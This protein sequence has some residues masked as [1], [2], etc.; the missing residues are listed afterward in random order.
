MPIMIET[1]KLMD[2]NELGN[3]YGLTGGNRGLPPIPKKDGYPK[4]ITDV[5]QAGGGA[6]M[7][8]SV[9]V[10]DAMR[11]LLDTE[12]ESV[13]AEG[14][15]LFSRELDV[16]DCGFI[17][18][19]FKNGAVASV[20]PSW[21]TRE[22][23][24]YHYDYYLNILQEN[25]VI[26]LDDRKQAVTVVRQNPVQDVALEAFGVNVDGLMLR[27]FVTSI[28]EG[29]H[30]DYCATGKDGLKALEIALAAYKSLKTG[31]PVILPLDGQ[32]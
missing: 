6:L 28:D 23:N 19:K 7:D 4:W 16:D 31:Q 1:K 13:F 27:Q 5:E 20:D 22:N 2:S 17:L 26:M 30:Q 8:H 10:T 14:D 24:P 21:I 25:G 29:V 18:L 12:V 3:I 9:H 15:T 32:E 11:F